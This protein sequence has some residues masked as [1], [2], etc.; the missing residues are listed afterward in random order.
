MSS[1]LIRA[2]FT[3]ESMEVKHQPPRSRCRQRRNVLDAQI[4]KRNRTCAGMVGRVS[5]LRAARLQQNGAQRTDA[6]YHP[7]TLGPTFQHTVFIRATVSSVVLSE[8]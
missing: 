8:K 4:K 6:P 2:T 7:S 3:H 5:P 1:R